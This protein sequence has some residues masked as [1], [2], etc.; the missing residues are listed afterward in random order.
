MNTKSHKELELQEWTQWTTE[1]A[2]ELNTKSR[3]ELELQEWTQWTTE[4]AQE[5]NTKSHKELLKRAQG[6]AEKA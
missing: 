5:L 6:A 3:K 4:R 1:R 2:Q